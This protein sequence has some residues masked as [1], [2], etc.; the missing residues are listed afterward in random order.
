MRAIDEP[1]ALPDLIA[2]LVDLPAP[3]GHSQDQWLK[4]GVRGLL[5]AKT[6]A[7]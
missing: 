3:R 7:I 6:V 4:D 1:A 2:E 5:R